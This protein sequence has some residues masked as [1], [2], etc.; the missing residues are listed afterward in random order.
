VRKVF[1][2]V[3]LQLLITAGFAAACL[4]S[5]DLKRFVQRNPAMYYVAWGVSFASVLLIAC[6]EKARRQ[7]PLNVVTLGVFTLAEAYL[8]GMITSFHNVEAVMLAFLVTGAAVLAL[9]LFA[10]NTKIDVTR[11]GSLLFVALIV[12]IVLSIIGIFWRTRILY[13]AISGIAALV[14]SAYLVCVFL[15]TLLCFVLLCFASCVLLVPASCCC[16]PRA[17]LKHTNQHQNTTNITKPQTGTTSRPSWA[18]GARPTRP[19][20]GWPPL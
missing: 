4:Y 1:A 3:A 12:L 7:F 6:V 15:L 2:I 11:W 16:V 14:F 5:P 20:T 18:A 19:T 17:N 13:L 8:V 9:T 10:I